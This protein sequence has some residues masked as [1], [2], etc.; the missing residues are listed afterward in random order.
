MY[1]RIDIKDIIK[2]YGLDEN[3][4]DDSLKTEG[5]IEAEA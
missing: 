4:S 2:E 5:N 3:E 1:I